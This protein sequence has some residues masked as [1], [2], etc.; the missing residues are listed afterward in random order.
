LYRYTEEGGG[1][2]GGGGK[3]G[4]VVAL[5]LSEVGGLYKL[6]SVETHSLR[7]RLVSST[8]GA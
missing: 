7:K 5:R 8:L 3:R 2:T 6:N 4:R 1:S